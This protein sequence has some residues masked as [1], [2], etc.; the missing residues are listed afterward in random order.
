LRPI[1]ELPTALLVLPVL[2]AVAALQAAEPA[3]KEV[4]TVVISNGPFAGTYTAE[5]LCIHIKARDTL[6]AGWKDFSKPPKGKWMSEGGI[7]IDY[8]SKPGPKSGTVILTMSDGSS[9]KPTAYNVSGLPVSLVRSG[10]GGQITFDGKLP[11]GVRVKIT[12]VCASF[13]SY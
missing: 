5:A 1:A 3:S 2:S 12:A 10:E 4:S 11:D 7:Q 9:A 6:G 13:D 8:L